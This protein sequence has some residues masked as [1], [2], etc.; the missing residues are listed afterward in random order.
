[1]LLPDCEAAGARLSGVT[2]GLVQAAKEVTEQVRTERKFQPSVR[3]ETPKQ[4]YQGWMTRLRSAL[5]LA[6]K[7][8]SPRHLAGSPLQY[9]ASNSNAWLGCGSRTEKCGPTSSPGAGAR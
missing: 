6:E 8:G 2:E 7:G 5:Q 3:K 9:I 4:R 1:M